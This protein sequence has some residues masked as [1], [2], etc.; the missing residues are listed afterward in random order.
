MKITR[1]LSAV[2]LFTTA[3]LTLAACGSDDNSSQDPSTPTSAAGTAAGEGGYECVEG[4]LRSSG[5]TAQGKVMEQ[6]ILNYNDECD[7]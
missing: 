7:A 4:E 5:S 2:A 3:A 6:W 1:K